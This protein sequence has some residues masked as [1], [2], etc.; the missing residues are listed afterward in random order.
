[1]KKTF[2]TA[3][4]L[5]LTASAAMA[6]VTVSG[7]GRLG[8]KHVKNRVQQASR[9]R[10]KFTLKEVTDTGVEYGGSFRAHEAV[11][12]KS[13]AEGHVYISGEYGKISFGNNDS[14]SY[15]ANDELHNIF[16]V[17]DDDEDFLFFATDAIDEENPNILY[18]FNT[19]ST[20]FFASVMDG[21]APGKKPTDFEDARGVGVK[22]NTD[23]YTL[24]FGVEK[25]TSYDI[26]Y[27]KDEQKNDTDEIDNIIEID[28]VRAT[29]SAEVKFDSYKVKSIISTGE[30][31]NDRI[32]QYGGSGE[33]SFGD[34]T[35]AGFLKQQKE[36]KVKLNFG[37]IGASYKL[38]KYAMVKGGIA[39]RTGGDAERQPRT[40]ADLGISL[41]F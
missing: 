15:M 28:N 32:H 13:G 3:A 38:N 20:T 8:V 39:R 12:A 27:K 36:P 23:R 29:V 22:F 25:G 5:I 4:A 37:G 14:A 17:G 16:L 24:G 40:Y 7:D 19:G 18:E 35:V 21:D 26:A 31:G 2:L 41:E 6:E 1:M 11:K 30:K 9:A 34:F 33:Y 10:I